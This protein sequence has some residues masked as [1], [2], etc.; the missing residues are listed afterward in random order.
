MIFKHGRARLVIL[1]A[2]AM[3]APLGTIGARVVVAQDKIPITMWLDTSGEGAPTV[4]CVIDNAVDPFN[5]ASD[6]IAVEGV[7]QMNNMDATRTALAGGAGPD[8]VNAFGVATASEPAAAGQLLPLDDYAERFGWAER[9]VAWSLDV[10][11]V[12]DQLYSIPAEIETLV[13]YYNKTLFEE[14]GWQPPK[15]TAELMTLAE[16]IDAAGVIPFAHANAEWRLANEWYVGEFL[17]HIAGPQ[18]VY[19]A[20]SG[21]V[22]WTDPAFVEAV[23]TLAE[24]QQNGWFM[25]GLERYYT[26]TFNETHGAL[27]AGEAA[28]NIEGTWFLSAIDN[29]FG[30]AAG[31]AN[32]WGWAPVPSSSGEAVFTLGIGS[33]F[34]IN[35]NSEN[36]DAAAEFLNYYFLPEVQARILAECRMA[37]APVDLGAAVPAGLD[38]RHADIL[39][40]LND[41]SAAN[42]YGYT[43]WTFWPPRSNTH[44]A[45]A[46][47]QVWAGDATAEEYLAELQE[48]FAAELAEGK[49]P[50]IPPR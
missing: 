6:T 10:G 21:R 30:E 46:V 9:F 12:D 5:A 22:P 47:E 28:M 14:H 38:P 17:N 42:N 43:T 34:S 18:K 20:L 33:L 37:P 50:T 13:L 45:E 39:A 40:A 26:A 35:K 31:N 16:E 1:L 3:V 11:R 29:Y 4:E 25:G 2:L 8:I 44:L 27:G 49:V 19:D 32:E 15:T 7:L 23:S 41:A 36:P 48:L 24:M